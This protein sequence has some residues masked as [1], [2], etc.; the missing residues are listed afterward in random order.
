MLVSQSKI[1]LDSLDNL[2]FSCYEYGGNLI[3]YLVYYRLLNQYLLM[4]ISLAIAVFNERD[5]LPLLY[6]KLKAFT[7]YDWEAIFVDDGSTDNSFEVLQNIAIQD[8]RIKVIKLRKNYGQTAALSA[9]FDF[10]SGEVVIAMDADLQNDPQDIYKLLIKIDEGFDVVSGWRKDRQ[11][12]FLSRKLPSMIAN[13][14]ISQITKVKLHDYGC[15]LKAYRSEILKDVK[16]Y[17]EMHRFIPAYA[18]WHG[19]KFTEVVVNHHPR[20][21]G[22]SKYGIGRTFKVILDLLTVKFLIDYMT[23]PMHF[24]GKVAIGSFIFSVLAGLIA[25]LLRIF[26]FATLIETPLPLMA[27][28]FFIIGVQF[29]LMGL[30]AEM[31]TRIYFESLDKPVYNIRKKINL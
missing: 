8:N 10:S 16:L 5:N 11:D 2:R 21:H 19:A 27:A 13:Y 12:K 28:F 7:G 24:F 26:G 20:Q 17:G 3:G 31:L 6:E 1:G 30:V 29:L 23:R 14:L 9:A 25:V 22:V 18:A 15:S 4:K